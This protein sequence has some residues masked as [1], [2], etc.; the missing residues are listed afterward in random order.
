M[1]A[2]RKLVLGLIAILFCMALGVLLAEFIPKW[3]ATVV[4][5]SAIVGVVL[6]ALGYTGHEDINHEEVSE[7]D[8][9]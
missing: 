8:E 7:S 9:S 4:I 2:S 5:V 1:K 3:V 6:F